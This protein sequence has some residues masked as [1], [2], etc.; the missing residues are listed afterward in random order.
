MRIEFTQTGSDS[1]WLEIRATPEENDGYPPVRALIVFVGGPREFSPDRLAAAGAIAFHPWIS[2]SVTFDRELSPLTAQRIVRCLAPVW[3]SVGPIMRRAYPV[4][5]GEAHVVLSQD[6][7]PSDRPH[8]RLCP[9][10]SGLGIARIG[11]ELEIATNAP[12]L[13]ALMPEGRDA[14][15]SGTLAAA[16][17]VGEVVGAASVEFADPRVAH[18]TIARFGPVLEASGLDV[19]RRRQEAA[20]L[21]T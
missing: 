7:G 20:A 18:G 11:S 8:F 14:R 9:L 12:I 5:R 3:V 13:D 4:P 17:I 16:A 2:G 10:R 19:V 15:G 21:V 6:S 1:E